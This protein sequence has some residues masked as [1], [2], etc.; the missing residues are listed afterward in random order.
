MPNMLTTAVEV[1]S[2]LFEATADMRN[3]AIDLENGGARGAEELSCTRCRIGS[4]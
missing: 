1:K 2:E 3:L 4:K